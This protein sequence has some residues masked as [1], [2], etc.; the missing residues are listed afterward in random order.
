MGADKQ[1]T[2]NATGYPA[3]NDTWRTVQGALDDIFEAVAGLSGKLTI[4]T[5]VRVV[6]PSV[7]YSPGFIAYDTE[8]LPFIGGAYNDWCTIVEEYTTAEYDNDSDSDG[9]N[10]VLPTIKNRY[11]RFGTG[12]VATFPFANLT[13]LKTILELS[14]FSL[15]DNIINIKPNWNA[16]AGAANEILNKPENLIRSLRQPGRA[17]I[18]DVGGTGEYTISFTSVNTS[19]YFPLITFESGSAGTA[20]ATQN[21]TYTTHSY[22]ATGF[23]LQLYQI[24]NSAQDLYVNYLLIPKNL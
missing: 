3:T 18:G 2:L 4:L 17:Y 13:R 20:G 11:I 7:I 14:Q 8:V 21:I 15:P 9:V 10:D 6:A 1:L 5:G 23:K 24:G 22:T 16:A 19:L 12:G